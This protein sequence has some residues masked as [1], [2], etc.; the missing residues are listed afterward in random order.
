M[1]ESL[2]ILVPDGTGGERKVKIQVVGTG[3]TVRL[4]IE[5]DKDVTILREELMNKVAQNPAEAG[6]PT[7]A[8]LS[9]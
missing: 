6:T 7:Q 1:K 8:P 2:Y 3:K 5:A 4:G 9:P